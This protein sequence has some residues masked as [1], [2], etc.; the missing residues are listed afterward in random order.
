MAKRK[1]Y[2]QLEAEIQALLNRQQS[3]AD[4]AIKVFQKA[5]FSKEIR[6]IVCN[7]DDK[8]LRAIA[9]DVAKYIRSMNAKMMEGAA[10]A[11]RV[12]SDAAKKPVQTANNTPIKSQAVSKSSEG[13]RVSDYI[14][15]DGTPKAEPR[16]Y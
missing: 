5:L 3:L 15:P 12:Q 14:N 11:K 10:K 6:S 7:M 4:D 2:E 8:M 13:F 1:S 16:V 9:K